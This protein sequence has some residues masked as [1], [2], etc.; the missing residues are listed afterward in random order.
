MSVDSIQ[1][2]KQI[3]YFSKDLEVERHKGLEPW[4]ISFISRIN[5]Y[6]LKQPYNNKVVV[7]IGTGSGY[8]AVALA[9][10]GLKVIATDIT[11]VALK[12][13]R[14]EKRK[15]KFE[16]LTLLQSSGERIPLKDKSADFVISNSV[17]EHILEEEKAIKELLRITKPG[18]RLFVTVPL[19]L[20]STWP[21]FWPL[22]YIHD[23]RIGHLRRYDLRDLEKKFGLKAKNVFY[24]GHLVKM[25]VAILSL[26]VKSRSI[27]EYAERED[28]K[29][30]ANSF[31]GSNISVIFEIPRKEPR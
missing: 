23:K 30:H 1:K 20:T 28:S 14:E 22:H 3:K 19:K 21:I 8:I 18:G 12:N 9:K 4:K 25:F 27:L 17:L 10:S 16:N 13:L 2:A 24:T 7:D 6:L 26:F 5:T 15:N 31:G 11:P 29:S